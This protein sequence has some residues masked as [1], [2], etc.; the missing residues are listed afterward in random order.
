M[1][2]NLCAEVWAGRVTIYAKGVADK[3][4]KLTLRRI[5]GFSAGD[6]VFM[7]KNRFVQGPSVPMTTIDN[8]VAELNLERVDF[9][10]MDIEGAEQ[11]ALAGA[12]QVLSRFHPRLAISVYHNI[13]D[14]QSIPPLVRKAWIEYQAIC[15]I[16]GFESGRFQSEFLFFH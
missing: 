15:G 7:Q 16:C 3:E 9:I 6:S 1:R 4:E 11:K 14:V 5:P 8:I 13:D 12:A 10:K 2:R